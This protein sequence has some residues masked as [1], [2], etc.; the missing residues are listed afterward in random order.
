MALYQVVSG[1]WGVDEWCLLPA[2]SNQ[3]GLEM[4]LHC[5]IDNHWVTHWFTT[6]SQAV[7]MTSYITTSRDVPPRH[8]TTYIIPPISYHTSLIFE[9]ISSYFLYSCLLRR[10]RIYVLRLISSHQIQSFL[11]Q[12]SLRSQFT[13]TSVFSSSATLHNLRALCLS[14]SILLRAFS[15]LFSLIT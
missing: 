6:M 1:H 12:V 5:M 9:Y 2:S 10:S 14:L 3:L 11:S 13:P 15:F 7:L 4:I 8:G